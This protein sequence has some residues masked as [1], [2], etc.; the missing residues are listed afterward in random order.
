MGKFWNKKGDFEFYEFKINYTC[1]NLKFKVRRWWENKKQRNAYKN[2][3]EEIKRK[4]MF[5][6]I[7]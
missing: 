4:A 2:Q 1:V 7:I 3:M 5:W 6:D